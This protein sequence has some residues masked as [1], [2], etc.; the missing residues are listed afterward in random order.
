[1][2][3]EQIIALFWARDEDA[4]PATDARYGRRLHLLSEG[5]VQCCE[6]AQ[7]CVND[8][9]LKTWD[10]IPPQRPTYFFAFLA[11]ICR[12]VSLGRVEWKNA[13]KRKATVVTLT[14]EM[15]QCIP[16]RW[17]E[18]EPEGEALGKLLDRFLETL[19]AQSRGIFLRRYWFADSIGEIAARYGITQS[20]VKTQ[21]YRTRNRLR[22]FL[23]G[24]GIFV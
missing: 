16:T 5:I 12:N 24:E 20:K 3:D 9:Y 14:R 15:E 21:L 23:E 22:Q 7:E 8:T 2:E 4:I 18:L 11:K 10:A 13:A 6:D 17:A 19:P 1:M